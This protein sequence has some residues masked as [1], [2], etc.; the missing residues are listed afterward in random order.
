GNNNLAPENAA[1]APPPRPPIMTGF[2]IP[3]YAPGGTVA[4]G[5]NVG[6]FSPISPS[7]PL[8]GLP[9]PPITRGTGIQSGLPAPPG[10]PARP[11]GP[12]R[13]LPALPPPPITRGTGIQSGLPAPP[14]SPARPY[15]T[16]PP[17]FGP[18]GPT[19]PGTNGL[20]PSG[21]GE[22]RF[23]PVTPLNRP[24]TGTPAP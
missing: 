22:Q 3:G 19:L 12:S 20:P 18:S 10:S 8:P 13:P 17:N 11:Y 15:G 1:P 5:G 4:P 7:S 2:P 14:G 23:Y 9:A 24:A 16:T 21:L 6:G